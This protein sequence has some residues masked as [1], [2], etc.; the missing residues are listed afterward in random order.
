MKLNI[1]KTLALGVLTMGFVA[2]ETDYDKADYDAPLEAS[3]ILP[4][5]TTGD[6]EL[7]GVLANIT[8]EMTPVEGANPTNWGLLLNT[9]ENLTLAGSAKYEGKITETTATFAISGLQENTKYYY[10]TFVSDGYNVAYGDTLAFETGKAWEVKKETY[11]FAT[12]EDADTHM[13]YR[14]MLHA[15]DPEALGPTTV[16]FLHN[17]GLGGYVVVSAILDP[18]AFYERMEAN[19]LTFGVMNASGFKCDFTGALFPAVTVDVLSNSLFFQGGGAAI[20]HFDVYVSN[21]PINDL[22]GVAGATKIGSSKDGGTEQKLYIANGDGGDPTI[23]TPMTF[24]VPEDFWGE[25]Y[26]YIVNQSDY[27]GSVYGA[28]DYG[29]AIRGYAIETTVEP[30]EEVVPEEGETPEEV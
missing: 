21:E 8:C 27:D 25:C 7:F 11:D 23:H 6:A 5:V 24:S 10:C 3:T 1:F 2:C 30:E 16:G 17:F 22:Y 26:V 9:S 15:T 18:V 4:E 29:I 13:P 12:A 14:V 19:L 20:G 28:V